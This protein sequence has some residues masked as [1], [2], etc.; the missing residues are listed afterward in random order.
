LKRPPRKPP[1]DDVTRWS[2]DGLAALVRHEALEEELLSRLFTDPATLA[3]V[4]TAAGLTDAAWITPHLA[5]GWKAVSEFAPLP[6]GDVLRGW[7]LY[8]K[9]GWGPTPWLNACYAEMGRDAETYMVALATRYLSP[10]PL[11]DYAPTWV[12]NAVRE[13]MA[14]GSLI[15]R[16]NDAQK[17][18]GQMVVRAA[19]PLPLV[20]A[21]PYVPVKRRPK[22]R[23]AH[24]RKAA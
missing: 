17:R 9:L 18:V 8:A 24:K 15:R 14:L 19:S 12:L 6:K 10:H 5:A 3:P 21:V 23:A 11:S 13:L 22:P 2:T 4:V 20:D 1:T 16:A 7:Q